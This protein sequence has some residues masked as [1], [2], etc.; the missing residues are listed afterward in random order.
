MSKSRLAAV[1]A[2]GAV[3]IALAACGSENSI[4]PDSLEQGVLDLAPAN[5]EAESASCPDDVSSDEGTEFTCTVTT[6]EGDVE[7]TAK[8]ISE[9]DEDVE[10]E[11]QSVE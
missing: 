4:E 8:V 11:V 10:F 2:A 3:A 6:S 5:V 1:S 9:G 7:V